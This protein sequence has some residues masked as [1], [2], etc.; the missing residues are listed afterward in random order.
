MNWFLAKI[1]YQIICGDGDHTPQF[2]EQ[3]R[4]VQ[5][6]SKLKAIQKAKQVGEKNSLVFSINKSSSGG[7]FLT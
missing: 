1:I 4:L 2:D 6:E 7:S 3:L 5:A